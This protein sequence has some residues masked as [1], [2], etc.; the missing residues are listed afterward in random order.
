[1]VSDNQTRGYDQ[2]DAAKRRELSMFAW[3]EDLTQ[4]R[5]SQRIGSKSSSSSSS[6]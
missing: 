4:M 5:S 3:G 1:L 6:F 2:A